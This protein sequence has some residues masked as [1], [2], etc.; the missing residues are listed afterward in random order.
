MWRP[1]R[2]LT[3]NILVRDSRNLELDPDG[4]LKVAGKKDVAHGESEAPCKRS[5]VADVEKEAPGAF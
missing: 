1:A 4:K 2:C 5:A 3:L